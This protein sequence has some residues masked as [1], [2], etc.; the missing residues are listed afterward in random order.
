[1]LPRDNNTVGHDATLFTAETQLQ[2]D[3][4]DVTQ[5]RRPNRP[6]VKS[7]RQ[8]DVMQKQS[9]NINSPITDGRLARSRRVPIF[10]QPDINLA[11]DQLTTRPRNPHKLEEKLPEVTTPKPIKYHPDERYPNI[12]VL[13]TN[14]HPN[15]A[16]DYQVVPDA[17]ENNGILG[18]DCSSPRVN[19][20]VI[21]LNTVGQCTPP[22]AMKNPTPFGTTLASSRKNS[23]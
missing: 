4:P 8:K 5:I 19:M 1:M 13:A 7:R 3:L 18:Y 10:D 2:N 21:D 9:A 14:R 17:V 12:Q 22:E 20:T 6:V 15:G 11:E 23:G 16:T